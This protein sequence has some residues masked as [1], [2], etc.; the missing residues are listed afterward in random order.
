VVKVLAFVMF[1]KFKVQLDIFVSFVE[2][3]M[4]YIYVPNLAK[5]SLFCPS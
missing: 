1:V 3:A 5:S 2:D 4:F